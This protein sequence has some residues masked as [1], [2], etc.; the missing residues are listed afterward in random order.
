MLLQEKINLKIFIIYNII[1]I[2]IF[3]PV[4]EILKILVHKVHGFCHLTTEMFINKTQCD[5]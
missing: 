5:V 4:S 2:E 3:N 1:K